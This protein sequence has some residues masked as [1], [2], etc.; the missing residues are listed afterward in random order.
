MTSAANLS[1]DSRPPSTEA[2]SARAPLDVR[3]TGEPKP[4][5]FKRFGLIFAF[6]ALALICLAPEQQGLTV[7][8]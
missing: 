6:I 4:G 8:G 1:T 3:K 2:N 5:F 7:A